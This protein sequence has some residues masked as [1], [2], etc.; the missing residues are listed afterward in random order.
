CFNHE[1]TTASQPPTQRGRTIFSA[2]QKNQWCGSR[3]PATSS[4]SNMVGAALLRSL[5]TGWILTAGEKQE[6][7][8]GRRLLPRRS[9]KKLLSANPLDEI[10]SHF[11]QDVDAARH[12]CLRLLSDLYRDT[13]HPL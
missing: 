5:P 1:P 13:G 4:L 12:R 7:A 3:A 8:V 2:R 9:G 11:P 6:G 10:F